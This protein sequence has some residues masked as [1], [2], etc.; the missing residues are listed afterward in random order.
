MYSGEERW[1]RASARRSVVHSLAVRDGS[2]T[3]RLISARSTNHCKLCVWYYAVATAG[4]G[5][6]DDDETD[7][8]G[9][10]IIFHRSVC[11]FC[12]MV[13]KHVQRTQLV[14]SHYSL[15]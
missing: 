4:D 3:T 14:Y 1:Q 11:Q 7:M 12:C 8:H 2:R 6:D 5:D 15:R 13:S 9:S 10:V